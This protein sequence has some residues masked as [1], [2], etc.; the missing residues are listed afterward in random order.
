MRTFR[1]MFEDWGVSE[2]TRL[3]RQARRTW[4]FSRP[5]RTLAWQE[6]PGC[7]PTARQNFSKKRSG[8]MRSST[9]NWKTDK[10]HFAGRTPHHKLAVQTLTRSA[11]LQVRKQLN[12]GTSNRKRIRHLRHFLAGARVRNNRHILITG[13]KATCPRKPLRQSHASR[14]R[15]VSQ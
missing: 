8:A 7:T 4:Q 12:S 1:G 2:T 11:Q 5:V 9:S 6:R 13:W 14:G 15:A 10:L 3:W